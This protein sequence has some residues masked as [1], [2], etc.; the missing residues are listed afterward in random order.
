[1]IAGRSN[2]VVAILT[3]IVFIMTTS[4][5]T[6]QE[7]RPSTVA[8]RSTVYAPHGAIATSQPL[9]TAAG[10]AVLQRGGNAID[11]AVTAAAVLNVVEPHMTGIG[12]DL[13]A[14]LWS[15]EEQR[16][17]GL[18]ASGRSGALMTRAALVERGHEDVPAF[19]AEPITVPGALSGWVALLERFGTIGLGE[20][21]QPAITIAERGFPVTPIIAGQW[22]R[23]VPRLARDQGARATFLI[24][25]TRAPRAGEW[26]RNP[27]LAQT[28]RRV[29]GGGPSVL[30]GGALGEAIV[31]HVQA[32]GGFLTIEDLAGHEVEWVEPL[33][34]SYNNY[35]LWELPPNGQGIAALEILRLLEPY[36][37]KSMGHNSA[38]YLHHLVEATK[39][40]FADLRH[41]VGDPRS[42]TVDPNDLLR[43][44]FIEQRRALFDP[45]R[46]LTRPSPGKAATA[47]ET[48][49]LSVADSNGNMVSLINSIYEAFGSHVVV[50]GTGFALQ[51]R[52][53]GFTLEPNHANTVAP[54]KRP[55]HT[56]IPGFVT[57]DG[58][59]GQEP[60][61]SYGVMGG[62]MQP[63]GHVQVLLNLVVF[64]MDL[65]DAIDAARYRH[66]GGLR[67]ALEPP[68][69]DAVRAELHAM[70]HDVL[71]AAD[72]QESAR[73]FVWRF[74]GGQAVM[75]LP[76]GWAAGSDPRKDGMAAGH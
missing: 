8:G 56:L 7:R 59:D 48:I 23:Q 65:Q 51:D 1:M 75:R 14:L 64:G 13:F 62:S 36:D 32:L 21:L 57:K 2:L 60:W 11:A 38:E 28:F 26:F 25:G 29:A 74:G 63:Q 33:S 35:R 58:G 52:G 54:K 44:E 19:G 39:I 50:P 71:G 40:A 18:N 53:A 34:V 31:D 72:Y 46:A 9:A 55:F 69:G 70:G 10:L 12:G 3:T 47:S 73:E 61:L 68:I 6:A 4:S 41:F 49:Y 30:Y 42:M 67:L 20:A 5:A 16:L 45:T 27:D 17:I 43:D 76:K 22:A 66:L 37:L 24:D 15:S